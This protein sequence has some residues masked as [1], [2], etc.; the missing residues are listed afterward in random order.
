[1]AHC[2]EGHETTAQDFCDVC[3]LPVV[4][5]ATPEPE[6]AA[7]AG[8]PHCGSPRAGAALFCESC[9]YDYTT[10]AVPQQ[11]LHTELGLTPPAEAPDD[12]PVPSDAAPSDAVPSDAVPSDETTDVPAA[13]RPSPAAGGPTG[14][15]HRSTPW[16]AEIWVDPQWYAFQE[17]SDPLPPQGPP[18]IVPLNDRALIGR[19]SASRNINPDIDCEPDAGCSRRQAYL[20]L[21]DGYW[22]LNDLD[23]ANGTYVAPATAS[24]PSDPITARTQIGP[25]LR[26]YVGAWTRIVVRPATQGEI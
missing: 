3:G 5:D 23:S 16:V 18:R 1:M 12:A 8:C 10:G 13:A 21:V 7:A 11:D 2:E 14:S 26:I 25:D 22:Y 15:L 6:P 17:A 19:H 4:A 9:G 24:L 20:T